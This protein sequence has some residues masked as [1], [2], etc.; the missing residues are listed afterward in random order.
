MPVVLLP[1][2]K[3]LAGSDDLEGTGPIPAR[4]VPG[5]PDAGVACLDASEQRQERRLRAAQSGRR[6]RPKVESSAGGRTRGPAQLRAEHRKPVVNRFHKSIPK[7]SIADAT[8]STTRAQI[9]VSPSALVLPR[10][11]RARS[12]GGA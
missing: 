1:T 9:S 12:A 7:L 10:V 11:R 4:E 6:T 2:P 3:G 5:R 8:R